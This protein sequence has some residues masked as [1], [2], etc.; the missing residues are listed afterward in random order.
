M[1]CSVVSGQGWEWSFS[2]HART[3]GE[4]Y[5]GLDLGLGEI[6]DDAWVHQR[7]QLMATGEW[8]ERWL[9][10][11]E[12]TWGDMWGRESPLGPPDQDE[13]DWLQVYGQRTWELGG[14]DEVEMRVGRQTLYY[15]SGR[16]LAS[17]EGANQRL[18]HDGVR[19]SWQRGEEMR[20]DGFVASPVETGPGVFDNESHQK[21]VMFWGVYAVMPSPLDKQGFVDGYYIGLR[22]E[23]SIF[24]EDG[25]RELRHTVGTRWWN[26]GVPWVY[27]T[28]LIFQFGEAGGREILAGAASLGVG[29]VLEDVR[30]RPTLMLRADAI[31]G[32]DDEG[33]L[34]TFH[35]LFQAN[36]YFNEG[37]FISP[38]NL[39]N[40]NPVL[41]LKPHERVT[42]SFGVNFQW[43]FSAEDDVY[44]PP[45]QRLGGPAPDGE[46]YLG[47][48][49]N[50]AV[51]WQVRESVELA[52]GY[53]HHEA[54]RSLVAVGG[55]DVEYFQA[56]FRVAF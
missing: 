24:V 12:L 5:R 50:A 39:Y 49:L 47:T 23:G 20:V 31:S 8:E 53:T 18:S 52:L 2:G 14:E 11:A 28:E 9:I 34:H 42:V 15:G 27:N 3:M 40:V 48:A 44:G 54:G 36:N 6:E 35:P 43:R 29:Y 55:D 45:L 46:R 13:G 16:L 10:A 19:V 25:G 33:T 51:I 17:R 30:W 21:E 37:G 41:T 38:S 22:D 32:G 1:G 4:S 7:V 56:S 26:E